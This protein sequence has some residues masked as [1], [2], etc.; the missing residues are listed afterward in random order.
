MR[1]F[2]SKRQIQVFLFFAFSFLIILSTP[3]E[4]IV[5]VNGTDIVVP[6]EARQTAAVGRNL[7]QGIHRAGGLGCPNTLQL[8]VLQEHTQFGGLLVIVDDR[9]AV[10]L[11]EEVADE[12]IVLRP[13]LM[14][15]PFDEERE[16][17]LRREL[18]VAGGVT[19]EMLDGEGVANDMGMVDDR[20]AHI[21]IHQVAHQLLAVVP[22]D[23]IMVE[24]HAGVLR[25]VDQRVAHRLDVCT[26]GADVVVGVDLAV[27]G[28]GV[29]VE[30]D[31]AERIGVHEKR[32][33]LG[34][35]DGHGTVGTHGIARIL[36]ILAVIA[37]QL[38][39]V[40]GVYVDDIVE[41]LTESHLAVV[42]DAV[43]HKHLT[44]IVEHGAVHQPGPLEFRVVIAQFGVDMTVTGSDVGRADDMSH[45]VVVVVI[46]GVGGEE[47]LRILH[48]HVVVEHRHLRIG[49]VLAPVGGQ[50][51]LSVNH[52][53]PF[54]EVGVVVDTV[55]VEAVGIERGLA[56]LEYHVIAGTCQLRISVVIGIVAEK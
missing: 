56:V 41:R 48:L 29:D 36:V 14:D 5:A 10:A 2:G 52:F 50:R 46:E 27:H 34:V 53:A 38:V 13:G 32:V 55:E 11:L 35:V 42:I 22:H 24:R 43:A 18:V 30:G 7:I 6:C 20:V 3:V 54:E 15:L 1:F 26:E 44:L 28:V 40:D 49:V 12:H 16:H 23:R 4:D 47:E 51:G 9:D 37:R 25:V 19:L 39:A 33:T 21:D 31:D 45:R 8:A 17:F